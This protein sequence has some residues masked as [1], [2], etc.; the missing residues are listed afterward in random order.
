[1]KNLRDS[2]Q[3]SST[4]RVNWDN[5]D[6]DSS[7]DEIQTDSPN[8]PNSDVDT[9]MR[10]ATKRAYKKLLEKDDFAGLQTNESWNNSGRIGI[11]KIYVDEFH[12]HLNSIDPNI[13]FT[14]ETEEEGAISFLDTKTTRQDDGFM[15]VSVYRKPTHTDRYLDFN[16]HHHIQ[17]KRSVAKTLLGRARNIPS[18]PRDK[19]SE[20]KHVFDALGANSYPVNFLKS[21]KTPGPQQRTQPQQPQQPEQDRGFLVLPYIKDVSE[22]ITRTL[23]KFNVRVAH[24]STHTISSI[25]KKPKDRIDKISTTGV[26]YRNC[27]ECNKVYVG[28]IS[29]A[30]KTRIKE[31]TKTFFNLDRNSQLV[32]HHLQTQHDFDFDGVEII[33][34]ESQWNK[35]LVLEA[36]HSMR[37]SNSINEHIYFP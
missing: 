27:K 26:V 22:K 2:V 29:R 36:W 15:L 19:S 28:Q 12:T 9:E 6:I 34:R 11:S 1:M 4:S 18:S 7:D 37:E 32:Q 20:T 13:Q 21:C 23:N 3:D 17:H 33:D 10:R 24:K 31:H 5:S 25:L 16:S 35:R 8:L 14:V 30:L